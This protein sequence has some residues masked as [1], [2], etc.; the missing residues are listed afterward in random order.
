MENSLLST[1][2]RH[3]RPRKNYIVR[4][5]LFDRLDS[6]GLCRLAII[7]GGAGSGKTTLLTSYI[8]EKALPG[9]KW[10]TLDHRCNNLFLFWSY[11]IEAL[12]DFLGASK[13]EYLSFF[14]AG[15]GRDYLDQMLELLINSLADEGDIYLVL[16]DFHCIDDDAVLSTFEYF[17]GCACDNLHIILLTRQDPPFYFADLGMDDDLLLIDEYDLRLSKDDSLRFLRET[18][19]LP[20]DEETLKYMSSLSEGWIGGLQLIAAAASGK[21]EGEIVKLKLTNRLIN[22][23]LTQEIFDQLTTTEQEFLVHTSTLAYFCREVCMVLFDRCDFDVMIE[24]LQR[25]NMLLVC[26]DEERGVYRYHHILG[27]YLKMRFNRLGENEKRQTHEKAARAFAQIGDGG[28]S[29]RHLLVVGDYAQAMKL[30]LKM[31]QDASTLS[32][33]GEIPLS[34]VSH[35][36]DFAYQKFFYHY[37]NFE[38]DKCREIYEM[39]SLKMSSDPAYEAFTG[40]KILISEEAVDFGMGLMTAQEI[41]RLSLS[42][43]TKALIM[44]KNATFMNY[45]SR[46]P[47]ALELMDKASRYMRAAANSYISFFSYSVKTQIYEEMGYFREAFSLYA[48]MKDA[49]ETNKGLGLLYPNFYYIGITGIFLKQLK[50]DEAL[51]SMIA[52]KNRSAGMSGWLERGYLYNMAEYLYISG[53]HDAATRLLQRLSAQEVYANPVTLS[54][55]LKYALKHGRM[56]GALLERFIARYQDAGEYNKSMESRL[57]YA[58]VL[59]HNGDA[60]G[61]L[62]VLNAL[63]CNAR[64]DGVHLK[65]TEAALAKLSVLPPGAAY[66]REA[67][68]LFREAV[69]YACDEGILLPFHF[70]A[71]TVLAFDNQYGNEMHALLSEKERDFYVSVLHLCGKHRDGPL[72]DREAEVLRELAAGFSNKE[73]AERLCISLSTV[74]THIVNIYGKLEVSSRVAAAETGRKLGLL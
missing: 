1:R 63:L 29:L 62:A 18:L 34:A 3:P 36:F 72:T 70:E 55:L 67:V 57:F 49:I 40:V 2:L 14:N 9:V 38:Y 12:S 8:K 15:I 59:R 13:Q 60:A 11:I 23:Y 53:D 68:S 7:K 54:G 56:S 6:L 31:P 48:E 46:Y 47:E 4:K 42:G 26:L 73:I 58:Q 22:E 41:E 37:S 65:I 51:E 39:M 10:I 20:Y 30:I 74:K 66:K 33:L 24:G 69:Y 35:D 64:R 19:A 17:V 16:D 50:L 32:Y 5:D 61:A 44:I 21:T 45:Q 28:E 52:A 25:K 27:G 71:E 43:A